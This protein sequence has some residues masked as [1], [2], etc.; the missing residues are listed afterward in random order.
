MAQVTDAD[1]RAVRVAD[2]FELVDSPGVAARLQA[3]L[4]D[5]PDARLILTPP[6]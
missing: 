5:L 3:D 4:A 1:F 2:E 6:T